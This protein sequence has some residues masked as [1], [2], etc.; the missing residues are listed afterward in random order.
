VIKRLPIP[1]VMRFAFWGCAIL[2]AGNLLAASATN[3]L[4]I[5]AISVDNKAVRYLVSGR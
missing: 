2:A 3:R 4:E 1:G 5:R